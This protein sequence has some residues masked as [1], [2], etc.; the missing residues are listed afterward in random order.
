[1][2]NSRFL[3]FLFTF[4]IGVYV[5]SIFRDWYFLFPWLDIPLHLLGGLFIGLGAIWLDNQSARF[6]GE[7]HPLEKLILVLGVVCLVG[8]FWEF[9]EFGL[10]YFYSLGIV[11]FKSQL[12]VADTIGDLFLD[13]LGGFIALISDWFFRSYSS[14]RLDRFHL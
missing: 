1:M 14:R 2:A 4:I 10:D 13:L 7:R 9:F 3:V 12:S 8:V 11:G 5:L 6:F